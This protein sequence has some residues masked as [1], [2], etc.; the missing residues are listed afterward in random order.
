M[1]ER[2]GGGGGGVESEKNN[3]RREKDG[4]KHQAFA[5]LGINPQALLHGDQHAGLE[6]TEPIAWV[7][8][9]RRGH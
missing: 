4:E 9:V 6:T 1:G 7:F 5:V 3:E 8:V 2:G